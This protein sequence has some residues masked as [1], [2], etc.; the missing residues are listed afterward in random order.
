[1]SRRSCARYLLTAGLVAGLFVG[2]AASLAQEESPP[3]EDPTIAA[4]EALQ[5]YIA[6]EVREGRLPAS[7]ASQ[8]EEIAFAL[9]TERI[10]ADADIRVLM[11]QAQRFTGERQEAALADLVGA[12]AAR[13]RLI[14]HHLRQLEKVAGVSAPAPA[15][16]GGEEQKTKKKDK[17]SK[18][19]LEFAPED[20]TK[21]AKWPL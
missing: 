12:A 16:A 5:G 18:I 15:M 1:M 10:R 21:D 13:E 8:A 4:F 11:L 2:V 7:A 19:E 20:L 17:K 14:F 3:P 9:E 6:E